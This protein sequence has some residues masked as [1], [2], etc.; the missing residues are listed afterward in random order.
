MIQEG[1]QNIIN[2][3]VFAICDTKSTEYLKT[4]KTDLFEILEEGMNISDAYENGSLRYRGGE[5]YL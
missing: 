2:H 1:L 4:P 3:A 5:K